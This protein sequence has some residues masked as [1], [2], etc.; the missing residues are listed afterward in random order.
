MDMDFSYINE[1]F[2]NSIV[3]AMVWSMIA[4]MFLVIAIVIL[5]SFQGRTGNDL[6]ESSNSLTNFKEMHAQGELSDEEYR[7][8]KTA[9]SG[10]VRN[11]INSSNEK[12]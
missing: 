9:V 10:R 2:A 7:T 5:R 3:A 6:P 1:F 11:E 12:S 4:T 8:I